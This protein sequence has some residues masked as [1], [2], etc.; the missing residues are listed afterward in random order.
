MAGRTKKKTGNATPRPDGELR[1]SQTITTYGPGSLV[2]LVDDAIL[3][4]GLEH[5]YY[6]GAAGYEVEAN[7]LARNL[8]DRGLALSEAIPFRTPPVN[9]GDEP[10]RGCG[11]RAV[12][13]PSWF[14]CTNRSCERLVHKR[15]T[16][17][18]GRERTHR[19]AT[20]DGRSKLVPVRF[21]MACERGHLDDFPWEW[22]VHAE[23]EGGRCDAPELRLVDRGSGDLTDVIV[24]CENCG[25]QRSM[26]KAKGERTLPR[27]KGHRPWLGA[28]VGD[29]SVREDC[30][31][32]QRLLV[33]TASGG[34]FSQVESALTIPKVS[35]LDDDVRD[36]LVRHDKRDLNEINS[37][38]E[39]AAVRKYITVLKNAPD[40]IARLSHAEL[41]ARIETFREE[42][43]VSDAKVRPPPVRETEFATIAKAPI[44]END[45][46][47][48][49]DHKELHP[50]FYAVK[51]ASGSCPLPPGIKDVVLIE[52]LREVRVL[53]G[54]T[55]LRAPVQN[56]YGEFTDS[57]NRAAL[58]ISADWLPAS[59]VRGE[60]FFLE[61]DPEDLGAWEIRP[62]VVER[63]RLLEK[64]WKLRYPKHHE[65]AMVFPG[66]RFYLLHTL[67]H[68]LITQVSLDCGYA[69]S[70]I[71]E[72]IY[73]SAKGDRKALQMAAILLSTGSS[74]SEGTLGGL[75]NQGRR[76][77]HHL[78]NA[79]RRAK[80]CSHDPVCGRSQPHE[81]TPGR[82]L[83]GAACHG[84]LFAA[85][86]SCERS[87]QY[88]DR[89]L[90]VPTMGVED[91][92][93]VAF[94]TTPAL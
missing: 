2:D 71:R 66:A 87:N 20:A 39:L 55:R 44:E 8:R 54:F 46:L 80:L 70:A 9:A 58:S 12:E 11:I 47:Y 37:A 43:G 6:K 38:A 1:Q 35:A 60:G 92:D 52:R 25:A 15:D 33:R 17:Y 64:G 5:W 83:L 30:D 75:V 4:P 24:G 13:F 40:F 45:H 77:K 86:C 91:A 19:C 90:V 62:A 53:T 7:D 72:R 79:L 88:L 26:A 76:I 29:G 94:F 18:K 57:S 3:I 41:W 93:E 31:E 28:Y 56:I 21:A 27:C 36:F 73:C 68:M 67:A 78:N 84:C 10:H 81:G 59:E 42:L 48:S 50:D 69:A 85:E 51:P 14:L 49:L 16:T 22:F 89:A 61:L 65:H 74:G 82:A 63:E 34:Y 32:Y 23:R